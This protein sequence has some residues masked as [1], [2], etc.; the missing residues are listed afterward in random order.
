MKLDARKVVEARERLGLGQ[1]ELATR[2]EIS[3]NTV[4]RVEH[5]FEIRPVTARRIARGLGLEVSDLYPKAQAPTSSHRTVEDTR[6]TRTQ[7]LEWA[8]GIFEGYTNRWNRE[9]D[10]L[11]AEGVFPYGKRSEVERTYQKLVDGANAKGLPASAAQILNTRGSQSSLLAAA[12]RLR[13]AIVAA[14]E[15]LDRLQKVEWEMRPD[16]VDVEHD[17]RELLNQIEQST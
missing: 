16:D 1:E 3:P 7:D 8:A 11:E 15:V 5:G 6:R 13:D 12:T 17:L 4:L 14:G 9:T 2:A 10:L